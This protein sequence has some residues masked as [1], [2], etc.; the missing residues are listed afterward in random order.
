MRRVDPLEPDPTIAVST[1]SLKAPFAPSTVKW[2][3]PDRTRGCKMHGM[4]VRECIPKVRTRGEHDR[5][6]LAQ[7]TSCA[8]LTRRGST[9]RAPC[10]QR[11]VGL[12]QVE[13]RPAVRVCVQCEPHC[14]SST[15][16]GIPCVEVVR[17]RGCVAS[18]N[19]GPPKLPRDGPRGQVGRRGWR[20]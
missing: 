12:D 4:Y 2:Q 13:S 10:A 11:V 15:A 8:A 7:R 5:A 1:K 17:A 9:E 19:R 20:G 16:V 6:R 14:G 3:S 18:P